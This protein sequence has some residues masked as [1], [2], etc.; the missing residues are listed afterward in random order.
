MHVP[1]ATR[2]VFLGRLARSLAWSAALIGTTLAVG[3]VGYRWTTTRSWSQAL[4]DASMI[5]GIGYIEHLETRSAR[6]VASSDARFSGLVLGGAAGLVLGPILH[7]M[8]HKFHLEDAEGASEV[9]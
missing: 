1:L 4:L 3:V 5:G 9:G 8:V 7:R 6:I 2:R